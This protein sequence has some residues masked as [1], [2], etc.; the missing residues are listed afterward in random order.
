MKTFMSMVMAFFLVL[1]VVPAM[2]ADQAGSDR[3]PVTAPALDQAPLTFQAL[4]KL[5]ATER[6]ALTPL[7]DTELAVIEGSSGSVDVTVCVAC[8]NIAVINQLNV[9]IAVGVG[10][11]VFGNGEGV[12]AVGAQANVA[13]T[14]QGIN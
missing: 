10:V 11:G 1:A 9:G 8:L 4:S 7:T 12:G 6:E 13:A 2:A 14:I 5:P 3:E